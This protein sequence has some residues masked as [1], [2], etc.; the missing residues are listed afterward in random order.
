MPSLDAAIECQ[1]L[2]FQCH[3]LGAQRGNARARHFRE[4][5]IIDIGNDFQQLFDALASNRRYDPEL[6]KVCA[7]RVD[8]RC[9]LPDEQMPC[10]MKHHAALLLGRLGRHEPHVRPGDRLAN[11]FRVSSIV[12]LPL[13]LGL[14]IGRRHQANGVAE[15][16]KL[17]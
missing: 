8:N 7:D 4:P 13:D 15:G 9:V 16:L 11:R 3:Q 10:A 17:P 14:H 5:G 6:G 2:G 1:Y 12:L